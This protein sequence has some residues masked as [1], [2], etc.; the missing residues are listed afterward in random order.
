MTSTYPRWWWKRK[1]VASIGW[2]IY[3][4]ESRRPQLKEKDSEVI[5]N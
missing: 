1:D 3:T 5:G 4:Q 2:Q